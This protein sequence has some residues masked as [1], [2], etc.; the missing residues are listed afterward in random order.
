MLII[1]CRCW[2]LIHP[3]IYLFWKHGCAHLDSL[4]N[5][6]QRGKIPPFWGVLKRKRQQPPPGHLHG[7]YVACLR[8]HTKAV[9]LTHVYT[10]EHRDERAC[11]HVFSLSFTS[12]GPSFSLGCFRVPQM[13]HQT[14]VSIWTWEKKEI[15]DR[16]AY[17]KRT[18]WIFDIL[19]TA[20]S[21]MEWWRG[22]EL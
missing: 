1:I 15:L 12:P 3:F 4:W 17:K 21:V 13:C 6:K 2:P 19:R 8:E 9:T 14:L 10:K 18:L 7:L 16:E 11:A 20:A 22:K 5:L